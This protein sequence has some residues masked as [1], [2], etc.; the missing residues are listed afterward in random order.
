[1]SAEDFNDRHA[2][3]SKVNGFSD[4][5]ALPGEYEVILKRLF[6]MYCRQIFWSLIQNDDVEAIFEQIWDQT[7]SSKEEPSNSEDDKQ[8][9]SSLRAFCNFIKVIG[10][11]CFITNNKKYIE[12]F[13]SFLKK[14][15]QTCCKKDSKY[16]SLLTIMI[17][18]A[19]IESYH[20]YFGELVGDS[21]EFNKHIYD[22]FQSESKA[23]Q[24][25][26]PIILNEILTL[27]FQHD[28][29]IIFANLVDIVSLYAAV[30]IYFSG[31]ND[32]KN[33]VFEQII[34]ILELARKSYL[35]KSLDHQVS[36]QQINEIINLK[37]F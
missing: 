23:E 16:K 37:I 33:K 30:S 1:M 6:S 29:S 32:L 20:E 10:N 7:P 19:F 28:V 5:E 24:L 35:D 22:Y 25:M 12:S 36:L 4:D 17:K 26:N 15:V 14:V 3:H 31:D 18:E 34:R 13:R 8:M 11:E 2:Y 21:S 27:V 9:M